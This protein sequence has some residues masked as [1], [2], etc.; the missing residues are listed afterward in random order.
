M[1]YTHYWTQKRDLNDQ[2]WA[3]ACKHLKAIADYEQARGIKLALEYDA[4]DRAP[5]FGADH[6]QWNG[7]GSKGHETFWIERLIP[8]REPRYEGDNPAWAFCKTAYKPYDV[9]VTA[10]LCYLATVAKTH[11]VTSDGDQEEWEPG[12]NAA[13]QALPQF[14]DS[15]DIPLTVRERV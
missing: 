12:L 15:L 2:E 7:S 9:S 4:P 1:G 14:A 5:H 10:A 11:E 8:Q 6:I 3:D 13:K